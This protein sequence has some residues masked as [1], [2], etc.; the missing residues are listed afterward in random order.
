[1]AE[2]QIELRFD[3]ARGVFRAGEELSGNVVLT[4]SDGDKV[5]AVELSVLWVTE[6]KGNTDTGLVWFEAFPE[7]EERERRLPFRARLPLLPRTYH[8]VL[9]KIRWVV[10]VRRLG[11]LGNDTISD[12]PFDVQ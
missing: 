8:G 5:G 11:G 7:T 6:G 9:L 3:D 4:A 2:P 10:R 1:M 12:T